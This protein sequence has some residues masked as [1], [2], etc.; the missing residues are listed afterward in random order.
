MTFRPATD[1][2]LQALRAMAVHLGP[3]DSDRD[4]ERLVSE[5]ERFLGPY[6]GGFAEAHKRLRLAT[7]GVRA[8]VDG[9]AG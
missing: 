6:Q 2:E 7:A 8:K 5:G 1:D 9:R 4:L 3:T